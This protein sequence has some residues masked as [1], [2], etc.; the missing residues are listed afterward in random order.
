LEKGAVP[1]KLKVRNAK[2]SDYA[3]ILGMTEQIH[4]IHSSH[5][6]DIFKDS[7][8]LFSA[9][10]FAKDVGDR[11]KIILIAE[12]DGITAAF[13]TV[14]LRTIPAKPG[15]VPH[16]TAHVERFCVQEGYRHR[17]IGSF[18]FQEA[19]LRAKEQKARCIE[20]MVWPFNESAVR[21]YEKEGMSVRSTIL[22]KKL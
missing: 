20:L 15:F 13:C 21:F 11:N 2:L 16:K 5:R 17:G 9:D 19:M 12:A 8:C 3:A 4:S 22:E 7:D 6:P 18:L 10:E 1:L 14:I